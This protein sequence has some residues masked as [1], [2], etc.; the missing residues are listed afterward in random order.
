MRTYPRRWA[1]LAAGVMIAALSSC[2]LGLARNKHSHKKHSVKIIPV[3][4]EVAVQNGETVITMTP[5]AQAVAG[6]AAEPLAK[7]SAQQQATGLAKVLSVESLAKLQKSYTATKDQLSKARAKAEVSNR[8]YARLKSRNQKHKKVPASELTAAEGKLHA[9]EATVRTSQQELSLVKAMARQQW[10][11][12]VESWLEQ[13]SPLLERVIHHHELLVEATLLPGKSVNSLSSVQLEMPGGR[14]AKASFVSFFPQADP[15][16][17][18]VRLLYHLQARPGLGPSTK[19]TAHLPADGT[20]NGVTVPSAAVVRVEGHT[21]VYQ[22][23]APGRFLRRPI[24]L[25]Q[26]EPEGYF[27][28]EGFSPGDTIVVQ[29]AQILLSEE[30]H[31][32][33]QAEH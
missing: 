18:G 29:G 32:G 4:C 12:T 28:R 10:G 20:A 16:R 31:S 27:V 25:L 17:Q 15:H 21:W 1:G 26:L 7:A 5:E 22:Q 8:E 6:I 11:G 19:L 33:V 9:D 14:F 3:Q 2:A 30:S 13:G 24:E 23:T